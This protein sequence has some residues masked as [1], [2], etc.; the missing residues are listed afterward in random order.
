VF[1][2]GGSRSYYQGFLHQYSWP[3]LQLIKEGRVEMEGYRIPNIAASPTDLVAMSSIDQG[4]TYVYVYN[5]EDA[6]NWPH[7]VARWEDRSSN[8]INGLEFTPDS[9]ALIWTLGC[10]YYWWVG[11]DEPG[12]SPGGRFSVGRIFRWKLTGGAPRDVSSTEV[13]VDVP[14]GWSAEDPEDILCSQMLLGPFFES[15]GSFRVLLPTGEW[16]TY[17]YDLH[18]L[19][20]RDIGKKAKVRDVATLDLQRTARTM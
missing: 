17:N 11:K 7:L 8:L 4:E 14:A 15:P 10:P 13:L 20:D 6:P 9:S 18:E 1:A 12:P 19:S 3:D 2:A 16:K 5:V